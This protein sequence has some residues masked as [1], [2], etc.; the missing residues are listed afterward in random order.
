ML[1]ASIMALLGD[2]HFVAAAHH[3]A[4]GVHPRSQGLAMPEG[5][6]VE[7]SHKLSEKDEAGKEKRKAR[8]EV[9]VEVAEVLVLA[10]VAIATAWSGYQAARWDGEQAVL[11]GHASADR[12]RAD[13]AST[14]GG[15]ELSADAAMFTAYLQAHSAGNSK[16]EA[17]YIRRFTPD[18]QAAFFAWLK[19]DPFTNAAAPPGPG[20]MPQYRNPSFASAD[21]LNALAEATFDQGTA[22]DETANRYV[23]DTVLFASV[24][25][26][27][28]IA[29]RFKLR[30][31]RVATTTVA[32]GV[33]AFTTF[34]L[35]TLP[36]R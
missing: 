26:L 3:E 31:V 9:A 25:F 16:L 14:L 27:V 7:I 35:L 17:F 15:Q 1:S 28:A 23:R 2:G 11:Y 8:W 34:A 36:R 4:A 32:M 6:N 5:H 20:Y 33:A 18:Y 19:T 24:L 12:F 21:R 13:A 10:I 30:S 22:A 29:Q